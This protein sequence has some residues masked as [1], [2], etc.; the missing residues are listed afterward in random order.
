MQQSRLQKLVWLPVVHLI[1][2]LL[3]AHIV[4][5]V[6]LKHML[7]QLT[8]VL[9]RNVFIYAYVILVSDLAL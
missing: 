2:K 3:H 7:Y 8:C 6:K 1:P 5:K 4:K 9:C